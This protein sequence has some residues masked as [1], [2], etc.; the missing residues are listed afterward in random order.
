MIQ[1]AYQV[2]FNTPAFLGNAEQVG[3]WRTPPFK[4]LLRQWWRVVY[5]PKV[6]FNVSDLHREEGW[7]FGAAADDAGSRQS[8]IRLRL[9]GGWN[10]GDYTTLEDS[11]RVCHP[12]V[13][14]GGP[15]CNDGPGRQIGA[16][17]YLGF[18]PVGV[19][20]LSRPPAIAPN[21]EKG[22]ILKVMA[23]RTEASVLIQAIELS[24]WFGTLGSRSRNGWGS[25]QFEGIDDTPAIQ[26]LSVAALAGVLRP[27]DECL[28]LDWPHAVGVDPHGPLVWKTALAGSWRHVMKELARIKIA[29]RTQPALSLAAVAPGHFSP[30]H[31][32][33][34]PVTHHRV[35]G[36]GWD[37][38]GRLGNQ[39]RFKVFNDGNQWYGVIVH[40][41]C[42][43]PTQMSDVLPPHQRN[44]LAKTALQTWKQVHNVLDQN[45]DR[46]R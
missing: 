13:Q 8:R 24:A 18:G 37:N 3:Q 38:K 34:Y 15:P 1:Y 17:L 35:N 14:Q 33:A 6:N 36:P 42:G 7:L 45:L 40:L 20:G 12:E 41:P 22:N 5:A 9:S 43:L 11:G 23:P 21:P 46:V 32:L 2:R 28:Q 10:S 39:L 29:F 25:L 44:S 16:N 4:A 30:R 27:L 31:L 19:G 26:P